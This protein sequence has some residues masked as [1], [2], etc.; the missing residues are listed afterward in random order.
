LGDNNMKLHTFAVAVVALAA[1]GLAQA[2][3][4]SVSFTLNAPVFTLGSTAPA[5]TGLAGQWTSVN[6]FEASASAFG[7]GRDG[8]SS[9]ASRDIRSTE[10]PLASQTGEPFG[11]AQLSVP[12]TLGTS[13]SSNVEIKA[14]SISG[15]VN[16]GNPQANEYGNANVS[17]VRYFE[18]APGATATFSGVSS[19]VDIGKPQALSFDYQ[20]LGPGLPGLSNSAF[21]SANSRNNS[22]YMGAILLDCNPQLPCSGAPSFAP[23]DKVFGYS[24]TPDG[25]LS[26]TISNTSAVPVYGNF[27]LGLNSGASTMAAMVPEPQTYALL[28]AGLVL[29]GAAAARKQVR[30][31]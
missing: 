3:A 7:L 26:L 23:N 21:L 18:L 24:T 22:V 6:N 11:V 17:W 1:S 28:L 29:V 27:S 9:G 16:L 12:A 15:S 19:F 10:L 25:L 20:A 13:A 2:E 31:S 14:G 5:G 8:R 4:S 30:S